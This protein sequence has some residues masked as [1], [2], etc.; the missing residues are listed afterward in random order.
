MYLLIGLG[1]IGKEYEMTR[2]NFGF[3][4]LDEI[5][6]NYNFNLAGKKLKSEIFSGEILQNKIIAIKPQTFMNLSGNAAREVMNFFKI[7]ISKVIVFHD[8]IDLDLGVVRVKIGGG[9]AGHNGIK[10]LDE[11]IGKDYVR[12]RM[13]VGRS[14]FMEMDV[15]DHVLSKFTPDEMLVVEKINKKISS[16]IPM[17]LDGNFNGFLQKMV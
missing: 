14:R 10:S 6:A 17:L 2:H 5:I 15:A 4:T 3:L 11:M 9:S 13:G 7:D 16:S 1:N 12:V 8:E